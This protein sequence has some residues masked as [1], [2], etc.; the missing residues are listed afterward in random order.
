LSWERRKRRKRRKKQIESI[1][2]YKD[3][4]F[5]KMFADISVVGVHEDSK[6]VDLFSLCLQ[7]FRTRTATRVDFN[8]VCTTGDNPAQFTLDKYKK[9]AH[10]NSQ[11]WGTIFVS[12]VPLERV[13]SYFEIVFNND[14]FLKDGL[15]VGVTCDPKSKSLRQPIVPDTTCALYNT[16]YGFQ[17]FKLV[18]LVKGSRGAKTDS[19]DILGVVVDRIEDKILFYLN[20]K[21]TAEGIKK[22]SEFKKELYALVTILYRD[23]SFRL[24]KKYEYRDLERPH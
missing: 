22:P 10:K 15:Y 21:C 19:R 11:S 18:N 8:F 3:S 20:G 1:P 2:C 16:T 9:G 6:A 12:D 23:S 17:M 5:V 7:Q 4:V 14:H 13:I 24:I